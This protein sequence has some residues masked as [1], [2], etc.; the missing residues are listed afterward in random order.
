[1]NCIS[2]GPNSDGCDPES[3]QRVL[4]ENCLFDTG[5]DCIALK[6]G[7]NAD[8]RRLA[9]PIQQVLIQDCLMKS[10]HG[11]VVIG[12][13]ISG[14]AKQI[15]AR[16]CRMSS[17]DLER[18]LRIKTNSVRGGLIEQVAVADIEIGEVK[19]AIV[20][21]F[22][23]EEGDAGQFLPQVKDLDIR[24]F[25]V[26]KAQRAFEI[27]GLP[28]S[29]ISSIRMTDVS[30]EQASLGVLENASDFK[31]SHVSMNGKPWTGPK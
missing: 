15:F 18:G 17:P 23:Y 22:Y 12:S 2:H 30:F 21:N 7:R 13:E 5:D 31:L 29:G 10:G 24:N 9:T 20:I 25:R 1:V 4:I 19:D 26:K 8:G 11:G 16:R 6:S 27:R 28:R 14:G 3:C